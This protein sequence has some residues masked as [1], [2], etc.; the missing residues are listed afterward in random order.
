[1]VGDTPA[2]AAT[3]SNTGFTQIFVFVGEEAEEGAVSA[4][5]VKRLKSEMTEGVCRNVLCYVDLG[6]N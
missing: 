3:H 5:S 6:V 2:T 1:M 4:T